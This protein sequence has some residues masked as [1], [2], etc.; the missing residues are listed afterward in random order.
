MHQERIERALR[1]IFD[2]N[3]PSASVEE[4][5]PESFNLGVAILFADQ[6]GHG[7]GCVQQRRFVAQFVSHFPRQ[8][9]SCEKGDG[10][11]GANAF[12]GFQI[13]ERCLRQSMQ[14]AILAHQLLAD[15]EHIGAFQSRAEQ[16]GYQ[17]GRANGVRAECP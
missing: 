13:L 3:Q 11:V 14:G 2:I 17:F 6:I 10:F 9:K 15:V 12:D 1:D 16:D 8:R 4:H 7:L 5:D